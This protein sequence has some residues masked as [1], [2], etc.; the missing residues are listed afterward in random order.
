ME[1]VAAPLAVEE[2]TTARSVEEHSRM[3]YEKLNVELK[4]KDKTAYPMSKNLY[5][6]KVECVRFYK[7]EVTLSDLRMKHGFLQAHIWAKRYDILV[8]GGF[9][10]LVYKEFPDMDGRLPDLDEYKRVSNFNTCF[11]DIRAVHIQNGCHTKA[12]KLF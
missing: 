12:T 8:I 11:T 3:F 6:K 7:E 5:D 4:E 9:G 1:E 10:T 2:D